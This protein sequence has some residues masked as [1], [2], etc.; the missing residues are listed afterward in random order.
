MEAITA[1]MVAIAA[2]LRRGRGCVAGVA[3]DGAV[4]LHPDAGAAFLGQVAQQPG[5]PGQQREAAQQLRRQPE[6]GQGG[7][8]DPGTVQRQGTTEHPGM[9]PADRLE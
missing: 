3:V 4:D 1:A 8:A 9:D 6:V 7:A 5:G 2:P